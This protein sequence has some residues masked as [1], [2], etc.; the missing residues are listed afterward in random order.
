MFDFLTDKPK[1]PLTPEVVFHGPNTK[2]LAKK[3]RRDVIQDFIDVYYEEHGKELIR[4][5]MKHDPKSF[6]DVLKKLIPNNMSLEGMEGFT[7][8]LVDR[9]GNSIEIEKNPE[10][11]SSRDLIS[12][13]AQ[14][15]IPEVSVRARFGDDS[16]PKTDA[17]ISP[18]LDF[19]L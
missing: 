19:T 4:A 14:D 11:A 17:G 15:V 9:Y 8:N 13:G 2:S 5:H 12:P 18:E 16:N 3:S 10:K 1:E 6:F 7:I